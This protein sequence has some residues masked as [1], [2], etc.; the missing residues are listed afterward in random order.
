MSMVLLS[1]LLVCLY[2]NYCSRCSY[3][4]R[5]PQGHAGGGAYAHL[6]PALAHLTIDYAPSETVGGGGYKGGNMLIMPVEICDTGCVYRHSVAVK[7]I[8]R[9]VQKYE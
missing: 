8:F 7:H 2:A 6:L 3:V 1:G 9:Y 4:A 5:F